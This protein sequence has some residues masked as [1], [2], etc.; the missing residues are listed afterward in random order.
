[1]SGVRVQPDAPTAWDF[2]WNPSGAVSVI[3]AANAGELYVLKSDQTVAQI[4][5]GA[6]GPE[7]PQGPAGPQ[8]PQGAQGAQGVQG[9]AGADG[10]QGPQGAAGPQG[11]QGIQGIKGDTGNAGQQ[12]PQG[13]QGIQGIQGVQGPAG[14]NLTTSAFGY[15]AGAG[16]TVTQ[17]TN[18]ATGVTLN[19]LSGQ[20]TTSNA[21]LAAAAEVTFTVTNNTVATTDVPCVAHASGGTAGAYDV[22]VAAVGNGS[23]A[24]TVANMSAGSL[25]QAIVINFVVIKGANA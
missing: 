7:G 15:T 19:K 17:L 24:I 3:L 6:V 1:M 22:F 9:V 18:K 13:I 23:F 2:Q 11:Q 14:P 21:A 16:G 25:S 20:I 8:G 12:G 10:A 4:G 5:S